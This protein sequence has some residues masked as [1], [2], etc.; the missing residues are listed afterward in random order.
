MGSLYL[1]T[2]KASSLFRPLKIRKWEYF[3]VEVMFLYFCFLHNL[4][5]PETQLR[6]TH[7]SMDFRIRPFGHFDSVMGGKNCFP[8]PNNFTAFQNHVQNRDPI[9]STAFPLSTVLPLAH[10][11][12]Q[13]N[14]G[15]SVF[16]DNVFFN[17][18]DSSRK[19]FLIICTFANMY[20]LKYCYDC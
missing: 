2:P 6:I 13:L 9:C 17:I 3:Q 11:N 7:G 1:Y 15:A 20:F 12:K 4:H 14:K 16:N 10:Q 19:G 5:F 8:E 18:Q